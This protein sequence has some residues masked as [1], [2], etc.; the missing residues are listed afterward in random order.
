M[1]TIQFGLITAFIVLMA[2][3]CVENSQKYKTL[4]AQRDSLQTHVNIVEDSY[5]Q[6]LDLLSDVDS[7][8]AAISE[9]EKGLKF[10]MNNVEG[11][12]KLKKDEIASRF[13]QLKTILN[14]NKTKVEKL[15]RLLASQDGKNSK[16]AATIKRLETELADKTASLDAL[17]KELAAKDIQIGELNKTVGTLNSNISALNDETQKQKATIKDQ[18]TSLNTVYYYVGSSKELKDAGIVT[19]NGLFKAKSVLDGNYN[20]SVFV[21]AD[22]RELSSIPTGVK[23]VKVLSNHPKDSYS[24]KTN[25]DKTVS[26]VI[27]NPEKFWSVSKYLVMQK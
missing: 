4:L 3:S 20:K 8:F 18:E 24:L 14:D 6:T 12:G 5:S 2:T 26:I 23:K 7:G 25:D 13:A 27:S 9:T 19:S 22:K 1:K 15:Q 10:E 16:L 11:K 17:Q 21:M